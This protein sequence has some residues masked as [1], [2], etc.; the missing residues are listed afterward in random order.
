MSAL[1]QEF[2]KDNSS[3]DKSG[4]NLIAPHLLG[5]KN[6][7]NDYDEIIRMLQGAGV[8]LN[9]SL[10]RNLKVQQLENFD[11]AKYNYV[12]SGKN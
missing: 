5:S 4:L 1:A 10:S 7:T 2:A 11:K 6:W 8:S 9:L 12:L 3:N